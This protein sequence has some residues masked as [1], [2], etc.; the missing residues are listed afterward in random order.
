MN[1]NFFGTVR[2]TKSFLPLLRKYHGRIINMGSIG[3]TMPSSFGSS[4]LATK[5]AMSSYNDC[6]R[7]E[8]YRFGVSVSIVEPGFFATELLQNGATA[9][10]A[11]AA[12]FSKLDDIYPNYHQKME[13]TRKPIEIMEWMNGSLSTVRVKVVETSL[14]CCDGSFVHELFF[15]FF[16]FFFFF[17]Y[18][19][20]I[21]LLPVLLMELLI[22]ILWQDTQLVMMR[23]SFVIVFLICP[24]GL[25]MSSKQRKIER[26]RRRAWYTVVERRLLRLHCYSGKGAITVR[27][28]LP[29][30]TLKTV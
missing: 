8:V 11:A 28:Y 27:V 3:A 22:A 21:R 5:A 14:Y 9:G 18:Y 26:R 4:Y 1:V 20:R 24:R 7:Q 15:L 13:D 29:S 23:E 2:M 10:A 12:T 16:F 30:S 17:F 25:W 19:K 6:V